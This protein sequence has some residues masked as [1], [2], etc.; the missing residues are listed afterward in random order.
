VIVAHVMGVP[1]EESLVQ[2]IPVGTMVVAA[3]AMFGRTLIE[4]LHRSGRK[5][6]G[7]RRGA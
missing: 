4:R 2:L 7:G 5:L 1:V 6:P 3:V